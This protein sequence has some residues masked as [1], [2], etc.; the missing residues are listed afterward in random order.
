MQ[1]KNRHILPV[2]MALILAPTALAGVYKWVDKDGNVHF[3][4]QPPAEVKQK[5]EFKA[6]NN[7]PLVPAPTAAP[8][9]LSEKDAEFRKRQ[10]E[11]SE[12]EKQGAEAE[13]LKAAKDERCRKMKTSVDEM[14]SG[15]RIYDY[16]KSG[17]RYYLDDSQ[18]AKAVD[19][20]K[21]NYNKECK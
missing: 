2:V 18:R 6:T 21:N 8:A 7:T 19:D 14:T 11:K 5:S 12:K 15:Y 3:G 9:S 10:I 17:Q 13:K 4:D 16:D 1:I 20:A